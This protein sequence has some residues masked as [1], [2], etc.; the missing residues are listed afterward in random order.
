MYVRELAKVCCIIEVYSSDIG[1][2]GTSGSLLVEPAGMLRI[3]WFVIYVSPMKLGM[4]KL[5]QVILYD[6]S[7]PPIPGQEDLTY[8]TSPQHFE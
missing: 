2:P 8:C 7:L 1:G 5:K 3:C 4:K 6:L